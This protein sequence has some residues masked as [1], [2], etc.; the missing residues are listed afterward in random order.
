VNEFERFP[1]ESPRSWIDRLGRMK[2]ACLPREQQ[3]M[4]LHCLAEARRL[5][6]GEQQKVRW[7]RRK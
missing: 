1:L 4:H 7:D 2:T 3:R 6:E 5:L